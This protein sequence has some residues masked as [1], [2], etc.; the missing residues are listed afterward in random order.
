MG[1]KIK[2]ATWLRPPIPQKDY[3]VVRSDVPECQHKNT[4]EECFGN[5][6]RC[7]DCGKYI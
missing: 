1:K 3:G 5:Y 4:K 2:V 7:K 6:T